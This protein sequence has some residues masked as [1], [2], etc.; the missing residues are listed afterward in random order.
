MFFLFGSHCPFSPPFPLRLLPGSFPSHAIAHESYE[1]G[2]FVMANIQAINDAWTKAKLS[3][4]RELDKKELQT[5]E[6]LTSPEDIVTHMTQLEKGHVSSSSGKL[7]NRVKSVTDR[8]VRFSKVIDMMTASNAEASLIWGSLKLLLTIVHQSSEI[9]EKI[10]QSLITVGESLPVVGL[11][12]ETFAHSDLVVDCIVRYYCSILRFWRKALKHYRRNKIINLFR[13]AWY[14]YNS[15]FGDFEGDMKRLC[16]ES[17]KAAHAVDM[18]EARKAREQQK[19]FSDKS[20]NAE[21]SQRHREIVKWLSPPARDA[22]YYVE[23]FTAACKD[24]H[25]G[26]CEWVLA[27]PEFQRWLGSESA[28][29]LGRM[30]WVFAIAGAGKTVVSA[31][32][33]GHC[34]AFFKA[35]VTSVLYFFKNTDDEKNPLL[36]LTRSLLHQLYVLL[37]TDELSD[38]L[39]SLKDDSGKDRMLSTG[40]A[41]ELFQKHAKKTPGLIL[42][43]DALDECEDIDELLS[44]IHILTRE[45]DIRVVVTSRKEEK[46][47]V[48]LEEYACIQIQP[49]DIHTDIECF[50]TEKIR[51]LT[52]FNS[53]SLQQRIIDTLTSRHEGMFLWVFLMIK[54]LESLGTVKAVEK[55][56]LAVPSGLEELHR[57]IIFR[58]SHTL[59][60]SGRIIAPKVLSWV[61][62]AIRPLSLAEI[63]EILRFEIQHSSENDDLLY[64]ENDIELI[65]GSLVT[66]RNG[67]LQL[68]H[69][70]TK[71]ILQQRPKQ[72]LPNDPCWPFYVDVGQAGPRIATLCVSYIA[73]HQKNIDSY[74]RAGLSSA[75]RLEAPTRRLDMTGIVNQNPFIEYAY[76]SWQAHLIDGDPDECDV[77]ELASLLTFRFTMLWLEFRLAQNPNS[78]WK[79]DIHCDV[80][81]HWSS[82]TSQMKIT[83]LRAW[84]EATRELV[85]K[86]GPLIRRFPDE[87][88]YLDLGPL[89]MSRGLV[90]YLLEIEKEQEQVREREVHIRA[91]IN[92]PSVNGK[93]KREINNIEPHRVLH[94]RTGDS[95]DY[96]AGLEFFLY[97]EKRDVFYCSAYGK[98]KDAM[99]TLW[100]QDRQTGQLLNP[101]TASFDGLNS[102]WLRMTRAIL[103]RD[104][105]YLGVVRDTFD[106]AMTT[107]IWEIEEKLPQ[108]GDIK[109]SQ[110]WARRLQCLTAWHPWPTWFGYATPC[111][112]SMGPNDL[113]SDLFCTPSGLVDPHGGV[114]QPLPL[115]LIG[116]T[117]EDVRLAYSGDG[118]I[119]FKLNHKNTQ[120]IEKIFW[121]QPE[122]TVE[123]LYLSPVV[124]SSSETDIILTVINHDGT[125]IVFHT[126]TSSMTKLRLTYYLMDTCRSTANTWLLFEETVEE[127]VS[128]RLMEDRVFVLWNTSL[129]FISNRINDAR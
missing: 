95:G 5:V 8:L 110:P 30:S 100:V 75:S 81:R 85:E 53:G 125:L 122:P 43:L 79:L 11:L 117:N 59:S 97:D 64:S 16:E 9:Y 6:T 65:C 88:H 119:L 111:S 94:Y 26:T 129:I 41:W 34:Q 68:I 128:P 83:F 17:Q 2:S 104:R 87:L 18:N 4:K 109:Q 28:E 51:K 23:D 107:S 35:P 77:C 52:R 92:G 14:D 120:Q 54:E 31:F 39:A 69:L 45:F 123:K 116:N 127:T 13:G 102:Y 99:E 112:L 78:L 48:Q 90:E 108:F 24:R 37:R 29:P 98:D 86:H 7:I 105:R 103:S 42:V 10:C 60:P 91:S 84:C 40:G 56:L 36:S 61:V 70:S 38:D 1:R 19:L 71:E 93:P 47:R 113:P 55:Q 15:E 58:L 73:A 63:Y 101:V 33:I 124:P 82:G 80:M 76:T 49:E 57:A 74:T 89:F 27:K 46:I 22:R 32:I 121:M 106:H 21:E 118:K 50:A 20:R 25:P 44:R 62:S 12:A 3:Y 126:S 96:Y 67:V 114:Q 115:S 72:M 66:T